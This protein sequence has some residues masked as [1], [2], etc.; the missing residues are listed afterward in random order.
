MIFLIIVLVTF[1][2]TCLLRFHILDPPFTFYWKKEMMLY[3]QGVTARIF[4]LLATKT[5]SWIPGLGRSRDVSGVQLGLSKG[6][7]ASVW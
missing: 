7:F 6:R 3:I 2:A 1:P 4:F 5:C